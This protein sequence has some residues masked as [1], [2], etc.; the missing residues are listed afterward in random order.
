[1]YMVRAGM[2]VEALCPDIPAVDPGAPVPCNLEAVPVRVRSSAEE[3]P[4]APVWVETDQVHEPAYDC[5]LHV[6]SGVIAA[7]AARVGHRRSKCR[8]HAQLGCGRINERSETR[9]ILAAS[10]WQ[11]QLEKGLDDIL[12]SYSLGW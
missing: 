1:M 9:M 5:S 11:H 10:V 2:P 7:S 8:Q 6:Y 3:D 12:G 4:V